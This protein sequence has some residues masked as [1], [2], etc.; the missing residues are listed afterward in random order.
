MKNNIIFF[1]IECIFDENHRQDID[2][3]KEKYGDDKINF[4]PEL[5]KILTICV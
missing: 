3:M 1:D 2:K 4:L 5:N